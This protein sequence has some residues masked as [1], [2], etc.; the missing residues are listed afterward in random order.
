[1]RFSILS[2]FPHYFDSALNES[3][4]KQAQK[5]GS[6][7][8]SLVNIRDFSEGKHKQADDRPYGG[9]PGMVMMA[10]PV[11]HA[12]R[13]EKTEGARVVYL[14]PQGT[15]FSDRKA[16]ELARYEHLILLCGHYEGIDERALEKEVDEE[17][18]I[19]D[20][21]LMS[22]CPAALVVLEATARFVPNVLGDEESAEQD[23]FAQ[24][25]LDYPHYT[26]PEVFEG[27]RVPSVL[28]SGNHAQIARWRKE[29]ALEKTKLVRPDIYEKYQ[30]GD[31]S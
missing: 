15:P 11:V 14:T 26:R 29:K 12:I 5:K 8:I 23:S 10:P 24:G 19:G 6:I 27:E 13:S 2:L 1:M 4:L 17:I 20:Y 18:S 21:V 25:L 16:R 3:M 22:G 7:E 28:L 31:K 9:G 30:C